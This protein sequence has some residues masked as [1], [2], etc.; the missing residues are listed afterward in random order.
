MSK[1]I[2][3]LSKT[4]EYRAWTCMWQRCRNPNNARYERYGGR[5]IRVCQRWEKFENFLADMGKRPS[6]N[7]SVDRIDNDGN[8]DPTNCRWA[9]RSEQQNNKGSYRADHSLPKGDDH[10]TRRNTARAKEIAREN[11]TKA[12]KTGSENGNA[13]LTE[14]GVRK[15]KSL[16]SSGLS[17]TSIAQ[18]F[19]VRPGTIWF[20][21]TGKNWRHVQ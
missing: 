18:D 11:I 6:K 1:I 21:R 19:G 14:D 4:D 10:W 2:H 15:I 3:G 16:I 12:H 20:I 8:Y 9:T 7:H 13:R 17:D 5:G